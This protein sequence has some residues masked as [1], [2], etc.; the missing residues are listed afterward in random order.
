MST[1][2]QPRGDSGWQELFWHSFRQ[3]RNAMLLVDG[4]RR[5][6]DVNGPSVRL[7]GYERRAL[8]G[9]PIW[10]LRVGGPPASDHEWQAMLRK[11]QFTGVADLRCADDS[12]VRVEFAG[13]PEVVTGQQLVLVVVLH[14]TR[15]RRLHMITPTNGANISSLS[16]REREVVRLIALGLSGPEIAQELQLAHNTVRTHV[17]NAMTKTGARSRAHLVAMTLASGAYLPRAA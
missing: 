14:T 8:I 15:T 7:L 5:V 9:R 10:E 13:H 16:R 4:Q 3:S 2:R 11:P 17:R 6:V 12:R 1:T